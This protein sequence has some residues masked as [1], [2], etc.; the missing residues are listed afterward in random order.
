M[1]RLGNIWNDVINVDLAV[2]DIVDGTKYKRGKHEVKKLLYD[3]DVVAEHPELWHQIDKAKAKEYAEYLIAMLEDGTW[4]HQRPKHRQQYCRNKTHGKGKWRKLS[5]PYLDDHIIAHMVIRASMKALTGG[6]HPHSCGSVPTRGIKHIYKTVK[7]WMQGDKECRYFVKLDIRHFFENITSDLL[8]AELR[9]RIKDEKVLHVFD[10][11]IDSDDSAC[12]V[13]YYTSPWL[14]N[15]LLQDL[16]WFIEQQL[17]KERRGKR[18]KYVRHY[19]RYVDDMLLIGTCKG[20]MVKAIH[21]IQ[22]FLKNHYNLEIKN[23]WEI[24]AIGKHEIV[25]G[26]WNLKPGT[27]W[28]DIGGY[29]FCKDSVIM[30]DGIYL[31]TK[32]LAKKMHKKGYYTLHECRSINSRIGWAK[33]C[34]S[35]N[36]IRNDIEP[37]IDINKTRKVVST[38]GVSRETANQ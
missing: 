17:Y 4:I 13:G 38:C 12:P 24:K 11:I 19:L 36:F 16:D 32:R 7:R 37:Y 25:D 23:S 31:G 22:K 30:R 27:Y 1:K 9:K 15:L 21:E 5:I 2:R 34:N 18:I 26:E 29:K 28:C 6:I 14:A 8:K 20:D 33:H 10:Q 3:K 35:N